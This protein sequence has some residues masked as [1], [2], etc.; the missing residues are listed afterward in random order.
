MSKPCIHIEG[1]RQHNLKNVTLDIPRDELVVVCGPSG[2]GK[3]TLAFD[4]V[5]AEGQRRYVE[6]LSAYARQ[7]LPQMDKP[8]VEKIEGLSPAI[9]LEQ[10][11]ATRNPRSTVGTVTEVYD[12]LRVFWARLGR[13]YCP[14]CGL[15]IEARA[16]DE[17]IADI[18]ALGEG[19]RCIVLAP[20]VEYQKGTHIDRFKKLKAEG[21]VRV[22]VN[23]AI[24]GIDEVPALDKNRKHSI[25]LVVDRLV[26]KDGIRGRLADSVELALRYGDGRLVVHLPAEGANGK[27]G[28]DAGDGKGGNAGRDIVHSTE[29][30]CPV[31][32]ISLPAPSPQLFSFNSP[33]G[34]CPRCLGLGSVEYFEPAL[35]A[36]N[37]GLS[38]NTGALLP[39]KNTKLFERHRDALTALGKRWGF[40]LSTPLAAYSADALDALFHGETEDGRPAGR[41][42]G[43]NLRRNWLGGSVVVGGNGQNGSTGENGG[44]GGHDHGPALPVTPAAAN[45]GA[46]TAD[47]WPGVVSILEQG[48][49][50]GDAWRELLSRYRQSMAC[51]VCSGARLRPESLSVRV[52]SLNIH[53]FCS[54]SVARALD[55]L[56]ERRFEGRH[57]LVAEPLMKELHHR[58]EFMVNVGLDYIALG[59]NMATLSGGEAQR[60]RLA[61]QLGSGLVGVTYVLDEPS[62][63]L[64]PRDNERLIKTLRSLQRRGNTVLVV[65]HDEATIREADTVI[66]LGP[67]SGALGGEVVFIGPVD[68][69]LSSSQSLTAQYL[70]GDMAIA[71][72]RARRAPRGWMTLHGVTTNNLQGIDCRVPLGVL[73]CVTGVS[74][75]GKS[76]LVMD[77]LYKHLALAQGI[78]VDQP[79]TIEGIEGAETI[80]RIVSIDQTPIGRTPRSNPAT[81]TKIF[82][83]IRG[84][85]AM[86]PD[87]RKRG[88]KPGRFSFNVRGGR[89]EACG[90]DGQIR[91]EMH[92]LPDV[93]V[94]CDVCKGRRYNHETLEV[95]YKGLNIAEVLDLTVR[96]ARQFFENYPV[97]ERRLGVLEDVGLE[98][99]RLGQ[100]ATTL[101]GGEAQRIKISRE[102]G[103]RSLP[104]T[105]YILDEPTTGL[106][107]H[108]VGK[109]ITVLNQLVDRGATVTVIE[110][111]TDVILA[112]DHVV[113]LGPGGGENG[114]RIVSAG[115]PEEIMDDPHSVT[116]SFLVQEHATRHP[117]VPM[118]RVPVAAAPAPIQIPGLDAPSAG[119][120]E[121]GEDADFDASDPDAGDDMDGAS[122]TGGSTA[123]ARP[124]RK[125]RA[126]TVD[127]GTGK[128]GT[129]AKPGKAGAAAV[130][131]TAPAAPAGPDGPVG[132][133]K[134]GRPRKNP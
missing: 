107:M 130:N 57:A 89:C 33:Q 122:G 36:P 67:G 121:D 43:S 41:G 51:P 53:E 44:S 65:E 24:M 83:E 70:R 119:D 23:G 16:A 99:L 46:V 102:L 123:S 35:V 14:Q 132:P 80:E 4:I 129:S 93:Y 131:T 82:D 88:Y 114:G 81:Y 118:P 9:S 22:R 69:L 103:K 120:A 8:E 115:T 68:T 28:K 94:T 45:G 87:A 61:S 84:I 77:T 5:Y 3:S 26:I 10:Q 29:S 116:G 19:T 104:G 47:R 124:G 31:C 25:D 15:P 128:G 110:H 127:K 90:G 74:G 71:R 1:A 58:L 66:E 75:S 101:S 48:M 39:W 32:R 109:L 40:T 62:I 7:F 134:R 133:R 111:N 27:D 42:A 34:A 97:L 2:S 20:L 98:Y 37:R 18:L 106:H 91:V 55:W 60:I 72:P 21:F 49:Q 100:P 11:T 12:F 117:G 108:E 113:D 13:M 63:G 105:M 59:R 73:T 50:Y 30:V 92:F 125:P 17:I 6:S 78:R 52:D 38:L 85:F 79:G 56:R 95:R 126:A 86:T 96:Q 76:S 64:H 54:M 112:S